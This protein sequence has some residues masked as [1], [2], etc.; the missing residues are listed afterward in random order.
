MYANSPGALTLSATLHVTVVAAALLLGVW[1][2]KHNEINPIVFELVDAEDLEIG[3]HFEMP[4]PPSPTPGVKY[5][6]PKVKLPPMPMAPP[7][8]A[9]PQPASGKS[10]P[11]ASKSAPA[12]SKPSPTAKGST[13]YDQFSKQ[14]A[15]E[16]ER[17]QKSSGRR[18]S[19]APGLDASG[20]VKEL[21]DS[22]RGPKGNGGTGGTRAMMA[23]RDAYWG[24]LSRALRAAHEM[25]ESVDDLKT[26]RVSFF[27]GADGS[28]SAVRI[29]KSSGSSAYDESV[30]EA[31]HRV[32][33]IGA[34]PG[35]RT[36]T[37]E[38]DFKMVE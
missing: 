10:A 33:S 19:S 23:A 35:G 32:R 13:S 34:V 31:F 37:F 15:K 11:A 36:G 12:T 27:I 4:G 5:H 30:I 2:H 9:E 28:I 24:R 25:P 3:D 17:N 29:L 22:A 21:Q 38:I 6:R 8:A 20:I 7:A 26:A 16:L 1:V 14:N 18:S